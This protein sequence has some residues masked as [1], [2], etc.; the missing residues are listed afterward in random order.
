MGGVSAIIFIIGIFVFITKEGLPFIFGRFDLAEFFTS[1]R[2]RPTSGHNP[3]YGALALIAGTASVTGLAM[4]V[5]VPCSALDPKGTEAVEELIWE[6]RGENTILIVT[7][8]MAQAQRASEECIFM[9]LGQVIE[10]GLTDEIFVTPQNQKTTDY[11]EGRY[12]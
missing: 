12:G 3:T 1:P 2:W 11:I 10:H 7:H 9:L 4:L 8:N 5:A 6:L